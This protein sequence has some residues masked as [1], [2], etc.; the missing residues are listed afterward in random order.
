MPNDQVSITAALESR[1][2]R[3]EGD[4]A[5][6]RRLR[7]G[8]LACSVRVDALHRAFVRF[9]TVCYAAVVLDRDG[10][11]KGFGFVEMASA[12]EARD[13]IGGMNGCPIE[14]RLVVVTAARPQE[15][16]CD[17]DSGAASPGE[18]CSVCGP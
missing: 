2:S 12:S 3:A 6:Q 18:S 16:W 4:Q 15:D 5:A 9:G 11:S 17:R 8:N 10:R 13:A 7:V 1:D 14:G